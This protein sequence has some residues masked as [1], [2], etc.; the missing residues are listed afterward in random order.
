[1]FFICPLPT[2][3]VQDPSWTFRPTFEF[4]YRDEKRND[5]DFKSNVNDN[6]RDDYL[7]YRVG[8]VGTSS[9]GKEICIRYLYGI[10]DAYKNRV[11]STVKNSD[12]DLGY[13]KV[14]YAGATYTIGR[15]AICIGDGRVVG[16]L[17]E[18]GNTARTYD[19]VRVKN[20]KF[21][22][23]AARVGT[24]NPY[25]GEARIGGLSVN[26]KLG[27]TAVIF[28]HDSLMPAM[29]DVWVLDHLYKKVAG[30]L[31]YSLEAM[32]ESGR[33][34][35]RDLEAWAFTANVGLKSGPVRYYVEG[36]MASGGG[37]SHKSYT[38]DQIYSTNQLP[39]GMYLMQGFRNVNR[40]T[41]GADYNITKKTLLT[42]SINSV[43]LHDASDYW[44]GDFGIAN[45]G[46]KG[47]Y[48]D[49]TGRSGTDIGRFAQ[50]EIQHDLSKH[51][52][53]WLGVG[54]FLPGHYVDH[55]NGGNLRTQTW[56]FATYRYKF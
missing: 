34:L 18:W 52:Q 55:M 29:T 5:R 2:I 40:I 14:P 37:N 48:V 35:N 36:A 11:H 3:P 26:T 30:K 4:R 51:D 41:L 25:S 56:A 16:S 38:Y 20:A 44:Y 46:P 54:A 43:S 1:M 10:D 12:L 28:K 9:D 21:D 7:R 19:G 8:L 27:A 6:K 13:L 23:F 31:D 32:G 45:V 17:F 15:Q 22:A 47:T 50:L 24:C 33:V 39:Y 42:G 53:I 49:P